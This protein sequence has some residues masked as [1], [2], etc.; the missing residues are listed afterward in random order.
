[1]SYVLFVSYSQKSVNKTAVQLVLFEEH[2]TNDMCDS[3]WIGFYF[4]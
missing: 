1:M 3:A 2:D 4:K